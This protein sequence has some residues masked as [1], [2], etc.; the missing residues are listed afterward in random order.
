MQDFLQPSMPVL[1][2]LLLKKFLYLEIIAALALA[3][4]FFARRPARWFAVLSFVIAMS[5][6]VATFG[7]PFMN[8]WSGP[9]YTYSAW[10]VAL[11]G[12]YGVIFAASAA[13]AV[14]GLLPGRRWPLVD[15]L[16]GLTFAGFAALWFWVG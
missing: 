8:V 11:G 16:H 15:L 7:P 9:F 14:S 1:A 4:V 2:F 10:L 13:L 6:V 12:G 3:R 5:G